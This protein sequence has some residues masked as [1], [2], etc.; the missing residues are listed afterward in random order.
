MLEINTETVCFIISK[1]NAFQ[2]KEEV[3]IPEE[4]LSP[5]DDWSRQVLADHVDDYTFQ[6][7]KSVI[8]DLSIEEQIS[9]VTLM[10]IGRGDFSKDEWDIAY[11]TARD[12]HTTWTTEYLLSTPYVGDY[13][14]EG[15]IAFGR[16]CD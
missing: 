9:L 7:T 8:H 4:P 3:V 10:W 15:L 2:A 12:E 11:Q 14:L 5:T 16:Y 1:A 6:E 13:L